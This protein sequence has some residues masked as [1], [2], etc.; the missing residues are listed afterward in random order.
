M[1]LRNEE[2]VAVLL[3][4]CGWLSVILLFEDAGK[5]VVLELYNEVL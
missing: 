3:G 1:V 4:E 2:F 5:E